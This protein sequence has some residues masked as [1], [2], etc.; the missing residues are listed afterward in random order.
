[1]NVSP[2]GR[3]SRTATPFASSAPRFVTSMV[4]VTCPPTFGAGS[5]TVLETAR[6]AY[7]GVSVTLS[8][9]F[10]GS[11]SYWSLDR[12]LAV[13]VCGCGTPNVGGRTIAWI[14]STRAKSV[15]T[16][17]TSQMPVKGSYVPAWVEPAKMRPAGRRS[18]TVTPVAVSRPR[19]SSVT[20]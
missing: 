13:L 19:F 5:S 9:L 3:R 1:M 4:N 17:P 8:V 15:S 18:V 7:R 2:V 10:D 16:V 6:S 20:V 14:D 12:T 11:G